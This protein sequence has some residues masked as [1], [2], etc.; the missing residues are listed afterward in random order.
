M[1]KSKRAQKV[2]LSKTQSK[3]RA[4]KETLLEEVRGCCD[5]YNSAYVINAQN[6]RN[7]ALKEV[8]AR[9]QGS[10]LFFGRTKLLASALGRVA[11]Q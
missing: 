11:S 9:L 10:R 1:P 4:R 7:T 3:G 6:M 8:R 2:T 5:S